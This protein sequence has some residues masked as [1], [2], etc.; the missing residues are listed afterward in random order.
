MKNIKINHSCYGKYTLQS[1]L[2]CESYDPGSV[3][4]QVTGIGSPPGKLHPEKPS[5]INSHVFFSLQLPVRV[6]TRPPPA[7]GE[8]AWH[9]FC[10]LKWVP[11]FHDWKK[12]WE[13]KYD[14]DG[15]MYPNIN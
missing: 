9:F 8:G 7:Q 2:P 3:R 6:K 10:T 11:N 15:Q 12:L 5:T 13:N 1:S 4:I 14:Y